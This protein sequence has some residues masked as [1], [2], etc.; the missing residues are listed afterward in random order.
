[1][2]D[3]VHDLKIN[4]SIPIID[5]FLILD[6]LIRALGYIIKQG[7]KGAKVLVEIPVNN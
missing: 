2:N 3:L 7:R 1:M 4:I 5:T 6:R